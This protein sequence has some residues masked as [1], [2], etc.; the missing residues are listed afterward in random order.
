LK[1][2]VSQVTMILGSACIFFL[3]GVSFLF[4]Y[5]MISNYFLFFDSSF[6]KYL[7]LTISMFYIGF[8]YLT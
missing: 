7:E 8:Y 6:L 5:I 4:S 3:M 2:A 1:V